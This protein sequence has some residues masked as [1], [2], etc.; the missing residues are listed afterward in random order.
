MS[1]LI[2]ISLSFINLFRSKPLRVMVKINK[3]GRSRYVTSCHKPACQSLE[4]EIMARFKQ[5]DA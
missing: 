2:N 4:D 1:N 5:G 3:A